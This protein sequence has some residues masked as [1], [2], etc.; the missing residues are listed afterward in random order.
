[1]TN[2]HINM[3][4]EIRELLSRRENDIVFRAVVLGDPIAH[5]KLKEE[6][7][8]VLS[9]NVAR[10]IPFEARQVE[11]F[12]RFMDERLEV[13]MELAEMDNIVYDGLGTHRI[14]GKKKKKK[15]KTSY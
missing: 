13:D 2:I 12:L 6:R 3:D 1:M 11:S 7:S 14:L 9:V 15:K 10:D 8:T 5:A 4:E